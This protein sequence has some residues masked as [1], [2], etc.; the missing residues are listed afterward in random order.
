MCWRSAR[1]SGSWRVRCRPGRP[2]K[3]P[4]RWFPA[5]GNGLPRARVPRDRGF[6]TGHASAVRLQERGQPFER[7]LLVRRSLREPEERAYYVVFAPADVSLAE[8]AGVAGLRW[9]IETCFATA[10]DELGLDHCEARSWHGW[11]RHM[12]LV[13]A[14]L[15]FLAELRRRPAARVSGRTR[16]WKT[17]RKEF[18][19]LPP[20]LREPLAA[21]RCHRPGDPPPSR[22]CR[23][24]RTERPQ[25]HLP[26]DRLADQAQ[27][28]G[29]RGPITNLA[30][31]PQL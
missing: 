23:P 25:P 16:R 17:E 13:M 14:A 30:K 28:R 31:K 1:T 7:W 12:T 18:C 15:A 11:H 2:L 19:A 29:A 22:L 8:L 3:S 21:A 4:A 26:M 9:T 5:T 10:K 6:T 24:R 20:A 27:C